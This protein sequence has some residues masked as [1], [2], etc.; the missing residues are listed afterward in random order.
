MSL[1]DLFQYPKLLC[2]GITA[3]LNIQKMVEVFSYFFSAENTEIKLA[4]AESKQQVTQV[5]DLRI[6][7]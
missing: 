4:I 3:L 5:L 6:R 7:T 2:C 1:P